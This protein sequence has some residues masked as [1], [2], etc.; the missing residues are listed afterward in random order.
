MVGTD[1]S[2]T[3]GRYLTLPPHPKSCGLADLA[4]FARSRSHAKLAIDLFCG[5]GGLSLGLARAGFDIALGIDS[6]GPA[7]GTHRAQFPGCSLNLEIDSPQSL[8]PIL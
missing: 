1:L 2:K 5:A 6:Y 4:A 3:R 8:D 7:I